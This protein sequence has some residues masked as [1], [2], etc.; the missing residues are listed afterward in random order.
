VPATALEQVYEERLRLNAGAQRLVNIAKAHG[1]KTLLVSVG[2]TFFTGRLKERLGL[3][4]CHANTLEIVNGRLTGH[5]LGD[6]VDAQ[7]KAMHLGALADRIGAGRE[8]IIAIGDGAND[9]K[10]MANAG[11]S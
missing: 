3:D 1:L 4:E 8:Q 11:Y 10:M 7:A 9:L 2:F 6:I 5:V